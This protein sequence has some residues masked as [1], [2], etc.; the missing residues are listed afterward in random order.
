MDG[1]TLDVVNQVKALQEDRQR[2]ATALAEIDATLARI[3]ELLSQAPPSG[4][5]GATNMAARLLALEALGTEGLP[6]KRVVPAEGPASAAPAPSARRKYRKLPLTGEQFV[7]DLL[8]RR[9][10]AST[11]EINAAWRAEGRGGVANNTIGRLLHQG[12]VVR[13]PLSER[14][15]SRYRLS[16][17]VWMNAPSGSLASR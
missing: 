10:S 13:E 7:L 16:E 8:R 6:V 14:R 9:G 15:G 3:G 2:H 11:L 12:Q 1:T 17:G 5:A 4:A